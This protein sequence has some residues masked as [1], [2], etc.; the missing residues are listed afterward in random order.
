MA[1]T[2]HFDCF[3]GISGDMTLAALLDLGVPEAIIQDALASLELP[4]KLVVSKI[5]KSGMAA[6]YIKVETPH[7]HK[8][9]H[10]K[11][12]Y[13][14]IDKGKLTASAKRIA[15]EMFLKLAEAEAAVHGTTIEKVH[16][17]EVGAVDSIFDFVGCAVGFDHLGVEQYTSRTVPTGTGT[18]QCEHGLMP[19]P[20]P[21]TA[22]LLQGVPLAESDVA[23]RTDDSNRRRHFEDARLSLRPDARDDDRSGRHRRRNPRS[24]RS[25]ERPSPSARRLGRRR[26]R[27]AAAR[28]TASGNLKPT[29]TTPPPRRSATPSN[30]SSPPEHLDVF[31]TPIQMKKLRPGVLIT[32]LCSDGA[33]PTMEAILFEETGTLGVRRSRRDRTKLPRREDTVETP[34]GEIVGKSAWDGARWRF[35]PEYDACAAVARE[36]QV[37]LRDVFLAAQTAFAA[38]KP[39]APPSNPLMP[40]YQI[41]IIVVYA[42]IVL[43][44]LSRHLILNRVAEGDGRSSNPIPPPIRRDWSRSSSPPRTR[45]KRSSA[46]SVRCSIRKE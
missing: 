9:R 14:I 38:A 28:P 22:L 13:E 2:L 5:K 20:A 3:S 39:S 18:V 46:A 1:K 42:I 24:A 33:R 44:A 7:E 45:R 17:H 30:V 34:W 41:A 19:I 25:S 27:L 4:G 37:P 8:H 40:G 21:A 11:H 29:S 43:I 26:R 6:T 35:A 16:F 15:R 31:T 12:I 32:V 23:W 10:L 36:H